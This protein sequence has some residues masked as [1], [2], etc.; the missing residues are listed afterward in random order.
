MGA[1]WLLTE[2]MKLQPRESLLYC[3]SP[4]N[5]RRAPGKSRKWQRK[6]TQSPPGL[7]SSFTMH[8]WQ[9]L[10]LHIRHSYV[11]PGPLQA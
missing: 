3:P 7:P 8:V 9:N 1:K 10:L 4:A 6:H 5:R 2:F 11:G